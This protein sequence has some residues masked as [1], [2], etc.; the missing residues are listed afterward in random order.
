MVVTLEG[1]SMKGIPLQEE[2]ASLP[3]LVTLLGIIILVSCVIPLHIYEGIIST[4]SPN[5]NDS[6]CEPNIQPLQFLAFHITEVIPLQP[7]K[8]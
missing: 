3:I 7:S 8:A 4:V 1:I 2:K 6:T 5:I